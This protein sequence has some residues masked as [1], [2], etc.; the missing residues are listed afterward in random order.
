MSEEREREREREMSPET[1]TLFSLEL[2]ELLLDLTLPR[3]LYGEELVETGCG[4]KLFVLNLLES[5][6]HIREGWP[7]WVLLSP[8]CCSVCVCVCVRER[9]RERERE[10]V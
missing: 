9:E 10:C 5:Q 7:F 4:H 1:Y 8:A 3:A 6:Q 2:E